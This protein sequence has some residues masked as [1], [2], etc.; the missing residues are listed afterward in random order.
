MA[1]Y[2]FPTSAELMLIEQTYLPVLT[3]D[4]PF[5]RMFPFK[6]INA[7]VIEWEQL[8][9]YIG[10]QQVRGMNG[11]PSRVSKTGAKRYSMKPGVYGE[12]ETLDEEELTNRRA[13]ATFGEPAIITDLVRMSQDKLLSRRIARQKWL[14]V[15]LVVNGFFSVLDK[16]GVVTHS[17]GYTQRQFTATTPWSTTASATPLADLRA[18]KL[19]A[20]G[21]SV[22][23]D[24]SATAWM[25]QKTANYMLNNS[26][27]AD[28]G[29][30]RTGGQG[31]INNLGDLNRLITADDLPQVGVWDKG[32][33]DDNGTFQLDI[34]DNVVIIEGNRETGAPVGQFGLT[35]NAN[36]PDASPGP[37]M[38]VID[39]GENAVPRTIEV[40]DGHNGGPYVLF[41]SAIVKMNV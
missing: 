31:T 20:R 4:N 29:G 11:A 36:N 18:I 33:Y 27:S 5:F 15:Q 26:N 14:I 9:N 1:T 8:D 40:H 25:N 7:A 21:Y 34:P 35:R 19:Y 10:L 22:R 12:F 23:F 38:R 32:Y 6:S 13:L 39:R 28:L 16:E 24:S 17:D 3:A 41:P 37:Y 2:A 30:K